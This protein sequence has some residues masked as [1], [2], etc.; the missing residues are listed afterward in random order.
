MENWKYELHVWGKSYKFRMQNI[1]YPIGEYVMTKFFKT[2]LILEPQ[3]DGGWTVTSPVLPELI[4]E[5]DD[6]KNLHVVVSDAINSVIELYNDIGKQIPAELI[7][8][9]EG[10]VWFESLI[11]AEA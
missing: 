11:P 4:T 6:L 5:V 10:P 3:R 8:G 9:S 7:G 2:L 1:Y